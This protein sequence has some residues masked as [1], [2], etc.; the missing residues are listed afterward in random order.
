MIS[1]DSLTSA[2]RPGAYFPEQ[3]HAP[4]LTERHD[5]SDAEMPFFR[6]VAIGLIVAIPVWALIVWTFL[7]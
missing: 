6:G 3:E 1:N 2:F 7:R 5:R 4:G